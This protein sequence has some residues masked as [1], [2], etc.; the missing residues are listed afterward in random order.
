MSLTSSPPVVRKAAVSKGYR[1]V[2]GTDQH[3]ARSTA[4]RRHGP[5]RTERFRR[6]GRASPTRRPAIAAGRVRRGARSPQ[7]R[8]PSTSK[9][10]AHSAVTAGGPKLLA[11]TT[12][13][14]PR[15]EASRPASSARHA[16]TSTRS[17]SPRDAT[18][19]LQEGGPADAALDEPPRRV[20]PDQP[21]QDQAGNAAAGAEIE[22]RPRGSVRRPPP[23]PASGGSGPR[24]A[25]A[26]GSRA[27]DRWSGRRRA[28]DRRPGPRA[29]DLPR[30]ASGGFSSVSRARA[31][32]P[33]DGA[34]PAH[35]TES[36]RR[37][38]R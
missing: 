17:A 32:S 9:G 16:N 28:P 14:L 8:P 6:P 20:G 36:K 37:R 7:M 18:A 3:T 29:P 13:W 24:P 1:H 33:H 5:E 21:G 19:S 4:G 27:R 31:R 25:S 35:P 34:V 12:S 11:R 26:R 2:A 23:S 38:A 10:A 22:H 30:L 15:I